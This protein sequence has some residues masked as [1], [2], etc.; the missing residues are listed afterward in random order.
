MLKRVLCV[1]ILLYR[2][3]IDTKVRAICDVKMTDTHD[4]TRGAQWH[5]E[6]SLIVQYLVSY[7][8]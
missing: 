1:L 3:G 2:R 5:K 4:T 6:S 8:M 7:D